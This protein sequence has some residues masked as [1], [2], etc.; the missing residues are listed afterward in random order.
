MHTYSQDYEAKLEDVKSSIIEGVYFEKD[1]FD[2]LPEFLQKLYIQRNCENPDYDE[3]WVYE[4]FSEEQKNTF[5]ENIM[6]HKGELRCEVLSILPEEVREKWISNFLSLTDYIP[7]HLVDF[8]N[9]VIV[10]TVYNN[11]KNKGG[12]NYSIGL[13]DSNF[14][15][16]LSDEDKLDWILSVGASAFDSGREWLKNFKKAHSREEIIKIIING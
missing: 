16:L 10:K 11:K 6:K 5:Y 14:F 15:N 13:R 4:L 2:I 7:Q 9:P 8:L 3:L 1:Y 12:I